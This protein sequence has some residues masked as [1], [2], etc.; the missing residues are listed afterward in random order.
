M[1]D[2]VNFFICCY[3]SILA[4]LPAHVKFGSVMAFLAVT[5]Q[6]HT[7]IS[8][9]S[10]ISLRTGF[11]DGSICKFYLFFTYHPFKMDI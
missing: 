2:N 9:W 7:L 10:Y 3:K 4:N 5:W 11:L 6:T 8:L 1:H